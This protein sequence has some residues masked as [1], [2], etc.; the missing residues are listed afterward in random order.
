MRRDEPCNVNRAFLACPVAGVE[1]FFAY[2]RALVPHKELEDEQCK[3]VVVEAKC[4]V[5]V[6]VIQHDG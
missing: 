5:L 1:M 6:L 2:P 4:A 3:L